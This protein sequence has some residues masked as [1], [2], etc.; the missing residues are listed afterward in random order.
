MLNYGNALNNRQFVRII[1]RSF[2][3]NTNVSWKFGIPARLCDKT[4][5]L[6]CGW[7]KSVVYFF[8][9]ILLASL[10]TRVYLRARSRGRGALTPSFDASF[11]RH[12]TCF[13]NGV[14]RIC[15]QDGQRPSVS[16]TIP[17]P[18]QT[19]YRALALKTILE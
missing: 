18:I 19:P 1:S 2:R 12:V 3:K 14:A 11:C 8:L 4:M 17:Y 13:G 5:Q 6:F 15:G 7:K 10:C 9:F 16:Y